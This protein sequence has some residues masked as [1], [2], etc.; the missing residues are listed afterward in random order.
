M[1]ALDIIKADKPVLL[2][3][4]RSLIPSKLY[5]IKKPFQMFMT[6]VLCTVCGAHVYFPSIAHTVKSTVRRIFI[7]E[8][9]YGCF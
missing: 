6:G 9:L 7:S 5:D 4:H 8:H 1:K 2:N 3:L